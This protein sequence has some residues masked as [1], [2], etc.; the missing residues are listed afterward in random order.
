MQAKTETV[1]LHNAINFES[2]SLIG[3]CLSPV[4]DVSASVKE[5]NDNLKL[6]IVETV[7]ASSWAS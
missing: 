4:V 2:G 5:K 7:A 1:R 3:Y 6:V